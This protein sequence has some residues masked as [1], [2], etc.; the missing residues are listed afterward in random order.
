MRQKILLTFALLLAIAQG[1]WGA[2]AVDGKLPGAFSVSA[3]K[4]VWFS[5][6][7]L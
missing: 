1:A 4:Q 7:N 3:T 6:G 2:I 5:Q